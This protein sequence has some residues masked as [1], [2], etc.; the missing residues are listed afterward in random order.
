MEIRRATI[1]DALQV[2]QW[3]NDPTSVAASKSGDVSQTDHI[4]WFAASLSN[5]DRDLFIAVENGR[6]VGLV[7]FD[8]H[9]D[10]WL[11]SI[12]MAPAERGKG[13]GTAALRKAMS[14][15][16]NRRFLAEVRPDNLASNRL[17]ERCGFRRAEEKD[18]F[19]QFEWP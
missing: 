1:D 10:T 2:L 13:Y 15:V 14:E 3:R 19:L 17:F 16:G 11:I 9:D 18:G 4:R 12:N 7:R 6:D 5:L 8:K